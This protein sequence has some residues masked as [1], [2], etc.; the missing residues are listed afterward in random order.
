MFLFSDCH[1]HP[2]PRLYDRKA[3]TPPDNRTLFDL[4]HA[5]KHFQMSEEDIT[6]LYFSFFEG[7]MKR[8]KQ[9]KQRRRTTRKAS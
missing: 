2:V 4:Q 3:P 1:G 8:T 7:V 6:D 5:A 9:A